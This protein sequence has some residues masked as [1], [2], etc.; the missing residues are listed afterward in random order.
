MGQ[1]TKRSTGGS[2]DALISFLWV[3][4]AVAIYRYDSSSSDWTSRS[5][6]KRKIS[7]GRIPS[8]MILMTVHRI[9]ALSREREIVK[10]GGLFSQPFVAAR[11][12]YLLLHYFFVL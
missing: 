12:P 8:G 3:A 9:D 6:R 7:G 5:S 10:G 1:N 11:L 4:V 2:E